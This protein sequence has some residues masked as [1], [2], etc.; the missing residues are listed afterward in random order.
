MHLFDLE[1]KSTDTVLSPQMH[2]WSLQSEYRE[3]ISV[4][5]SFTWRRIL[6]TL[7]FLCTISRTTLILKTHFAVISSITPK[8]LWGL[9][10]FAKT[11][12]LGKG[13]LI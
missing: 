2:N 7:K 1:I 8:L 12:Q 11:N 10:P 4:H 3:V 9:S 6:L 13:F 5:L